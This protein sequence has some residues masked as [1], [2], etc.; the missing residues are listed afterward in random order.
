MSAANRFACS[1][2]R[3]NAIFEVCL[4]TQRACMLDAYVDCPWRE[5]A[6]WFHDARIQAMSGFPLTGSAAL[7]RR[8]ILQVGQQTSPDGLVFALAPSMGFNHIMP[9]YT[10]AWVM[11][12]RDYYRQSGDLDLFRQLAGGVRANLDYYGQWVTKAGLIAMPRQARGFW[13]LLPS[14]PA[15][16]HKGAAAYSTLFNFMY[17]GALQAAAGLFRRSGDKSAAMRYDRLARTLRETIVRRLYDERHARFGGGLTAA[18]RLVPDA[19]I[20]GERFEGDPFASAWALLLDVL[21]ER[22]AALARHVLSLLRAPSGEKP[23]PSIWFLYYVFE[24]LK[25]MGQ[26]QAVLTCIRQWWWDYA[27][28]KGLTTTPEGWGRFN[29]GHSSHC[30]AWGAHPIR[31]LFNIVL[32]IWPDDETYRHVRFRPQIMGLDWARGRVTT[33]YGEIEVEWHRQNDQVTARLTVP[34]G[35]RIRPQISGRIKILK[36]KRGS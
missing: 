29:D 7:F 30:H 25:K 14:A 18:G 31:H 27:I 26:D 20:S 1:D 9:D 13:T 36:Q 2:E 16:A 11:S 24:A 19:W 21:P 22:R 6:Q 32:G 5:Q 10:F 35:I 34:K 33:P 12:F 4:R 23:A 28:A 15:C 8:A 3:L 17:L